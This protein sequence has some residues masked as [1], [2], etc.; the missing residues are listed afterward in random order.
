MIACHAG[1]QL[2]RK[3][4]SNGTTEE[5]LFF[6]AAFPAFLFNPRCYTRR[7]FIQL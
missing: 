5:G 7:E 3:L 4:G 2:C 1:A 6:G